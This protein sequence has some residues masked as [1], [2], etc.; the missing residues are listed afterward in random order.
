MVKKKLSDNDKKAERLKKLGFKKYAD[1]MDGIE[2]FQQEIKF[3]FRARQKVTFDQDYLRHMRNNEIGIGMDMF[4]EIVERYI[5]FVS[6]AGSTVTV[7]R[8]IDINYIRVFDGHSKMLALIKVDFFGLITEKCWELAGL[9]ILKLGSEV[10]GYAVKVER[11]KKAE[12]IYE[13]DYIYE[14][15]KKRDINKK[16]LI[17]KS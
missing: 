15:F 3:L 12:L 16:Q 14:E 2:Q 17:K 11:L 7:K 9:Y 13:G 4:K 5:P 8:I 10:N 6:N 1:G